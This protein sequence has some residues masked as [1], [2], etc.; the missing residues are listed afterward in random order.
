MG[1]AV[2]AALILTAGCAT[3]AGIG[4]AVAGPV[5]TPA[6]AVGRACAAAV[7]VI[8]NR[9]GQLT[10]ALND[11]AA[12]KDRA[13]ARAQRA[14]ITRIRAIFKD[15]AGDMRAQAGAAGDA[16]LKA[17]LAQYGAAVDATIARVHTP[18]DLD[19]LETFD[20]YELDVAADRFHTVCP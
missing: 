8:N 18:D 1:R 6:P 7:Q 9:T 13:D 10:G 17:V 15:W 4:P 3:T 16:R 14:A 12:A 19:K 2:L 11:A 20:D 5:P